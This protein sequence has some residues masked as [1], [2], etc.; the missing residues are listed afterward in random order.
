MRGTTIIAGSIQANNRK[1]GPGAACGARRELRGE[2]VSAELCE[3][4]DHNRQGE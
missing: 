1:A 3:I 4:P 2:E